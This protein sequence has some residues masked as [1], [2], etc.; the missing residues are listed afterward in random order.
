MYI[1][2]RK[3]IP[4]YFSTLKRAIY[5]WVQF[6]I[7]IQTFSPYMSHKIKTQ[8]LHFRL[9][10]SY[11]LFN[12]T[13]EDAWRNLDNQCS[14]ITKGSIDHIKHMSIP[15]SMKVHWPETRRFN[16]RI[17]YVWYLHILRFL[18]CTADICTS[19]LPWE[20]CIF[21]KIILR[22]FKDLEITI[23]R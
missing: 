19:R 15:F 13:L 23:S 14:S 18:L 10:V 1:N 22:S 11:F 12:F 5:I 6:C 2:Y 16:G 20:K 9:Q 4:L 7:N 17:Y 3:K 8:Y 21:D